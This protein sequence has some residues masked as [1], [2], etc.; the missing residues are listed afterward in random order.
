MPKTA[1]YMLIVL[2][3]LSGQLRAGEDPLSDMAAQFSDLAEKLGKASIRLQN[4]G[5]SGRAFNCVLARNLALASSKKVENVRDGN[6][7]GERED[8]LASLRG[9]LSSLKKDLGE[10][11]ER[12]I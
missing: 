3:I 6:F 1:P 5:K 10:C 2:L 8:A 11:E 7:V 12:S 4:E 9:R